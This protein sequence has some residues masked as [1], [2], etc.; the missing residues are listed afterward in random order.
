MHKYTY[1]DKH[2]YYTY[3]CIYTIYYVYISYIYIYIYQLHW[4]RTKRGTSSHPN[5]AWD[6]RFQVTTSF[7]GL[8]RASFLFKGCRKDTWVATQHK[9]SKH[10]GMPAWISRFLDM[11]GLRNCKCKGQQINKFNT[12][13]V[14]LQGMYVCFYVF[15]SRIIKGIL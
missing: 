8:D 3:T 13:P 14:F 11:L 4:S 2:V 5:V 7:L 12:E 6:S 15:I 9:G 1:I 10:K